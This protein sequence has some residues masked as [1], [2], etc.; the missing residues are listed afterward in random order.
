MKIK[1]LE[2]FIS[3]AKLKIL[4]K[5][6]QLKTKR[7]CKTEKLSIIAIIFFVFCVISSKNLKV[8]DEKVDIPLCLLYSTTGQ[9]ELKH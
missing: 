1:K 4:C 7:A 9:Y 2:V 8:I 5:K 3:N 6:I